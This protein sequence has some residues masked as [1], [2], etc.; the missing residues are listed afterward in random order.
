MLILSLSHP[1]SR[2]LL[3]RVLSPP[4][5]VLFGLY[6]AQ[7]ACHTFHYPVRSIQASDLGVYIFPKCPHL[8][9]CFSQLDL[10]ALPS[11]IAHSFY[12]KSLRAELGTEF[13]L[14]ELSQIILGI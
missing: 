6:P 9:P 5:C 12:T 1:R 13:L 7:L 8:L 2:H 4:A 3:S 14:V 11:V 10:L